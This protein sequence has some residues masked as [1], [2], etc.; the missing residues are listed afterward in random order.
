M[1]L[2]L[3]IPLFL[4]WVALVFFFHRYRIWLLYYLA[5]A[6]GLAYWL[7]YLCYQV[8]SVEPL[9]AQSVAWAVH[10]ATG[11]FGVETR[12]FENA[13]GVLLVLVLTQ[14]VGWTVLSVGVE[15]S[16]LLEM[17]VL[18]SLVAFYPGWNW[19]QRTGRA[20]LGVMLT[21]VVNIVRMLLISVMIHNWGKEALVLAHTFAGKLIF[22]VLT[23][24]I[25]WLLLTLPSLNTIERKISIR[26][27]QADR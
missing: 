22:F 14:R 6:A 16:G 1:S 25:Y 27:R 17:V 21:W 9:L 19:Q 13:P 7:T 5:G 18:A 2:G 12:V 15:S 26:Y 20:L 3:A 11:L 23:V 24:L 4:L 10:Q 8:F